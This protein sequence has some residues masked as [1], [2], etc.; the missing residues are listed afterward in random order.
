MAINSNVC[1]HF[2]TFALMTTRAFS[3]NVGKLFSELKL[4][5]DNLLS[6]LNHAYET[7]FQLMFTTLQVL[8]LLHLPKEGVGRQFLRVAV[9]T[10]S[11]M[12]AQQKLL[13]VKY[14]VQPL[15]KPLDQLCGGK[16]QKTFLICS[17]I[18]VLP[19]CRRED[20]RRGRCCQ[21]S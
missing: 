8:A 5:T 13:T 20:G 2:F 15:I 10:I 21:L 17:S 11:T 3:R 9:A 4:V 6:T 1:S 14:V 16:R 18:T 7:E 12:L 19:P